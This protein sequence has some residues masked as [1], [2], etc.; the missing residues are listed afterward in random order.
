MHHTVEIINDSKCGSSNIVRWERLGAATGYSTTEGN[1]VK[2]LLLVGRIY[3]NVTSF[4]SATLLFYPR[5]FTLEVGGNPLQKRP[6]IGFQVY[7]S[8]TCADVEGVRGAP[9]PPPRNYKVYIIM[10]YERNG[11][12]HLCME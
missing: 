7:K 10:I 3:G 2:V 11:L 12:L 6:F 4:T 9:P 8:I 5:T 1:T